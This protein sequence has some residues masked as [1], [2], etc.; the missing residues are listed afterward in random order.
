MKLTSRPMR[1]WRRL[2]HQDHQ[3]IKQPLKPAW[4]QPVGYETGI[5]IYNPIMKKKV[6]LILKNHNTAT[7]YTCGPTVYDSAHIGHACSYIRFDIIRRILSN[8]FSISVLPVMGITDI[9]DKIIQRSQ[10]SSKFTS[11]RH[12]S[13]HYE[14]EFLSEMH[15]LNVLPP[16]LHCR[17]T[18]YIPEII[19]FISIL[20]SKGFA[21]KSTDN[22]IY[23]NTSN[24]P[25][26]GKLR[27]PD[28]NM[29]S[30]SKFSPWDFALWK[31]AKPNEP[32]WDS[33]WGP[34]RPGWHIE[35]S[36]MASITLGNNIDIHSGG[37]DLMFP[38]HENEEAQ[39]CC[40]HETGQWVNYWLHS[41]LLHLE[42]TKMSKSLQ[43]TITIKELLEKFTADQF[44]LLCL[45]T[46][47]RSTIEF[48][49][50][51]MSKAVTFLKKFQY[52]QSDCRNYVA[53]RFPA[54]TVD[55]S[56]IYGKLRQVE[57]NILEA[58]KN[59]FGTPQVMDELNELVGVVNKGLNNRI[60]G[61]ECT[62][63]REAPCI[64]TAGIYVERVLKDLGICMGE[65]S[66]QAG[67]S[68]G[69]FRRVVDDLVKFRT[70][71]RNRALAMNVKDKELLGACD[72]V[73]NNLANSGI[74]VKDYKD[75][76][77]WTFVK[78]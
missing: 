77:T 47:Y 22:S 50:E 37:L 1:N 27:R 55:T 20:M 66:L 71:V 34:G 8:F 62:E 32:F 78:E 58:L 39:S 44:R 65:E 4:T 21:Y 61:S 49:Q 12:L 51:T 57:K 75:T 3:E 30:P 18:D 14:Q 60:Q 42:D 72:D 35:C 54:A 43:N 41:G 24:Y 73:R 28:E 11:W 36:A 63:V 76:A 46:H 53:G 69:K 74:K 29:T 16:Y 33:P 2:F 15:Q 13:N 68:D 45:C 7:W 26:Y 70:I 56:T 17:V 31:S 10:G 59:D 19:N 38:H 5:S 23:F 40:H 6:P 52:F 9:D 67:G 25:A 48:S 64:A